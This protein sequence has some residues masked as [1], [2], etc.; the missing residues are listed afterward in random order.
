MRASKRHK[1]WKAELRRREKADKQHAVRQAAKQ[2]HATH[3][4]PDKIEAHPNI[5]NKDVPQ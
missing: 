2:A 4:R 5:S 1:C 3:A